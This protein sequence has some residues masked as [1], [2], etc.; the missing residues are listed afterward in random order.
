MSVAV[1]LTYEASGAPFTIA[2]ITD[3]D[4][5]KGV[6]QLAIAAAEGRVAACAEIDPIL[7]ETERLEL[8][9]LKATLAL[10]IGRVDAGQ[11]LEESQLS[12][13]GVM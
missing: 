9:R 2:R 7:A 13:A 12:T 3:L 5:I 1:Y 6:A 10:L 11:A 4:A 8:R